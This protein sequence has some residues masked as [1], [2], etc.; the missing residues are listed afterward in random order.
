[1]KTDDLLCFPLCGPRPG[2]MG[3][4]AMHDLCLDMTKYLRRER[5][6]VYTAQ[7]QDAAVKAG[8]KEL[9]GVANV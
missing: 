1:M 5:E 7:T 4:H 8:R 9:I 6:Y 3:C 2:H